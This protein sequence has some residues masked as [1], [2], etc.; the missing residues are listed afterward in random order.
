[1]SVLEI[2]FTYPVTPCRTLKFRVDV[3]GILLTFPTLEK[4]Y[5]SISGVAFIAKGICETIS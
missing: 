2:A 5:A 1:V 4:G 3:Q